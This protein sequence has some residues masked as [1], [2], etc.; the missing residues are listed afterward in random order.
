MVKIMDNINTTYLSE[1]RVGIVGSPAA[2]NWLS[3]YSKP[4]TLMLNDLKAR[5]HSQAVGIILNRKS[6]HLINAFKISLMKIAQTTISKVK[7]GLK[8]SLPP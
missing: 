4:V 1:S 8:I 3:S 5:F 6:S 7:S 2:L